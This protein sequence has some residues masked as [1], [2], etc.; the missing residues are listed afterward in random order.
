MNRDNFLNLF[1]GNDTD[2]RIF[3]IVTGAI[4]LALIVGSWVR[5]GILLNK[6]STNGID[7]E[8]V[9][10]PNCITVQSLIVIPRV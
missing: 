10:S 4:L 5:I 3:R 7:K 9:Y 1:Q 6:P 8:K 2:G